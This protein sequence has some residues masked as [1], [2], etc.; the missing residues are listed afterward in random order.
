M[1]GADW[2]MIPLVQL[3]SLNESLLDYRCHCTAEKY[4]LKSVYCI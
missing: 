4:F 1:D 3:K 2:Q